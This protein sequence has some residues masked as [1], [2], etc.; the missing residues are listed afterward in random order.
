MSNGESAPTP[1]YNPTFEKL[2]D[3]AE[4]DHGKLQGLIAYGLY[5][6]AKR[7]WASKI[8]AQKGRGPT[9]E[10]L[11][12]YIESWT[13]SR[14]DGVQNEAAQALAAYANVVISDAEPRILRSATKGSFW[15]SFGAS[16]L[17]AFV[18]ALLLAAF[19]IVLVWQGVDILGIA[20]R[21]LVDPQI[22]N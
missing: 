15:R 17:A 2:V 19:G 6:I 20:G 8:R 21:A 1:D 9:D 22:S 5:K 11:K 7:E 12:S 4:S 13:P 3:V 14:L 18:F 10:E 16:L